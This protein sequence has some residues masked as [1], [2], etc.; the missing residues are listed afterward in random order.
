MTSRMVGSVLTLVILLFSVVGGAAQNYTQ[1]QWGMN[2]GVTPYAF[3]AN[4]NGTWS[5]LGTVNSVGNWI[6]NPRQMY[7][8]PSLLPGAY[9]ASGNHGLTVSPAAP[10]TDFTN[11]YAYGGGT[12]NTVLIEND[13]LDGWGMPALTAS[14]RTKNNSNLGAPAGIY[15]FAFNDR[16]TAPLSPAWAI[17][18][19]IR[20]YSGAGISTV[21]EINITEFGTPFSTDPYGAAYA[22][23]NMS[24]GL[25]IQSGG[26]CKPTNKC[27]NPATGVKDL[28]AVPASV[29]LAIGNNGASFYT[30]LQFNYNALFGNDG[31][32]D[33]QFAT[34]IKMPRND[35]VSW[36]YCDNTTSYPV[37][38]T[39][40]TL[41][42]FIWSDVK[43]AASVQKMYFSDAAGFL[44]RNANNANMLNVDVNSSYVNGLQILPSNT[45]VGVGL[46]AI[47]TDTNIGI[48]IVPKGTGTVAITRL[49]VPQT[50]TFNSGITVGVE[51]STVGSVAFKNATS[52]TITL[53][54]TTGALG[55]VTATLPANTGTIAETNLAQTFTAIQ[56]FDTTIKLKGYTVAGL[57]AAHPCNAGAEGSMAYVTD[58]NAPTYNTAVAGGGAVK[59]PVFCDGANWTAH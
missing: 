46:N 28:T 21:N 24:A 54:P 51:G 20:R 43:S 31:V 45:G 29:A 40:N 58:A 34:A 50:A 27:Y 41:G 10:G 15:A 19:E 22:V 4:I 36:Y 52:G 17:Y 8:R 38:C 1:I 3:G 55:T 56:T 9:F 59:V 44:L 6:L 33:G 30:G 37:F 7:I 16:T 35:A 12:N 25:Y 32:T 39:A 14:A 49:S 11:L 57:T 26:E 47:G 2:K 23:G 18:D 42:A 5:D 13:A 53:Q 48:N